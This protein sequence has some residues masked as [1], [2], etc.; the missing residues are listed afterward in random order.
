M[1]SMRGNDRPGWY[2]GDVAITGAGDAGVSV[3]HM[4]VRIRPSSEGQFAAVSTRIMDTGGWVG[5]GRNVDATPR[6]IATGRGIARV[7]ATDVPRTVPVANRWE[8]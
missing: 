2:D 4:P 3:G 8:A 6:T 1:T 5:G 7:S